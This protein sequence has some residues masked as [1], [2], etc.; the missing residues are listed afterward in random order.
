MSGRIDTGS[1][2]NDRA[3]PSSGPA[4]ARVSVVVFT[5]YQCGACRLAHPAMLR[6]VAAAGDVRVVYRDLPVFG[7]RSEQ[8]ALVALAMRAQGLYPQ[9]HDALM[10]EPRPLDPPVLREVVT[11][12]G[13]DWA[14]A[15]RDAAGPAVAAQLARN[16]EDALRLGVTGTPTYLIGPYRV[17]GALKQDAFAKAFEQAREHR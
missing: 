12:L 16:G 6:A 10:R 8:A 15:E 13:G 17:V 11:R 1:L 14:R 2:L 3:S 7:P 5:D 9:A 4:D